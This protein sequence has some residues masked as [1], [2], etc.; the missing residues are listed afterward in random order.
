MTYTVGEHR[1]RSGCKAVVLTDTAPGMWPLMGYWISETGC[2]HPTGWC[3]DG[4]VYSTRT[5]EFD[6]VPSEYDR[7]WN[8]ALELAA[9]KLAG[10]D[11]LGVLSDD[12]APFIRAMR[13]QSNV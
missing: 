6:L 3:V 4:K 1:T 2:A 12:A 8:E 5:A 7:G 11:F 13:K 9:I 10:D